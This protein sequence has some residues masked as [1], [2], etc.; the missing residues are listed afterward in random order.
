MTDIEHTIKAL[1]Y[2]EGLAVHDEIVSFGV[3]IQQRR[4]NLLLS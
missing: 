2:E 1:A 3:D 4:I